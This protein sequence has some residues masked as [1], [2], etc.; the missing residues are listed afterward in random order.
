MISET[1]ENLLLQTRKALLDGDFPALDALADEVGTALEGEIAAAPD[2][3]ARIRAMAAEN[4]V[5]IAAASR[6]VNA[7]R[8]RLA[9]QDSF[10]TYDSKG[11][12]DTKEAEAPC[13]TRRL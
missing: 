4:A 3:L 7:A 1:L 2:S 9:P 6:G 13:R 11:K 5:L 12:R 8:R 10:S